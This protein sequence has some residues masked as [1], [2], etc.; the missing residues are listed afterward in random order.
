ME[1]QN[2]YAY[3]LTK[4]EE[5]VYVSIGKYAAWKMQ[6]R[7]EWMVN[8]CDILLAIWDGTNGG[9]KNCIDYAISKGMTFENGKI[10]RLDPSKI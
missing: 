8:N 2:Q 6:K 10:I 7:N 1:N 9:T 5:I 3:W 4:A